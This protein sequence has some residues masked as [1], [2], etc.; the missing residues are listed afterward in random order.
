MEIDLNQGAEIIYLVP[1]TYM[2][3]RDFQKYLCVG[4][5]TQGYEDMTEG[6]N[7]LVSVAILEAIVDG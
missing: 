3:I 5:Q 4:I 2:S 6:D 1:N 7:L